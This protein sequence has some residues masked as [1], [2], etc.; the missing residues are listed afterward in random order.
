[1]SRTGERWLIELICDNSASHKAFPRLTSLLISAIIPLLFLAVGLFPKE[2]PAFPFYTLRLDLPSSLGVFS[3]YLSFPLKGKINSLCRPSHALGS[4]LLSKQL[5]LAALG[6]SGSCVPKPWAGFYRISIGPDDPWPPAEPA[7]PRELGTRV[8][9]GT[10]KSV[11]L[12]GEKPLKS[13][14]PVLANVMPIIDHPCWEFGYLMCCLSISLIF[15]ECQMTFI[16]IVLS[17]CFPQSSFTTF[18]SLLADEKKNN[19]NFSCSYQH[20]RWKGMRTEHGK[21]VVP[22]A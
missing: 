2:L 16:S 22:M 7:E 21:Q 17:L 9:K 4:R 5:F 12:R 6:G 18:F 10:R 19:S 20:L 13:F 11:G 1:M 15:P 3:L 14:F 8:A